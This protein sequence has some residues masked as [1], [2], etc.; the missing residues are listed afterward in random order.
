[1]QQIAGR[2]RVPPTLVDF[3]RLLAAAQRDAKPAT[4]RGGDAFQH[5]FDECGEFRRFDF[6][7]LHHDRTEFLF[8]SPDRSFNDLV[9]VDP[10]AFHQAV[11]APDAAVKAVFR[12]DVADFDQPADADPGP[13]ILQFDPVG[14]VVQL[15][16]RGRIG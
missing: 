15:T 6:A 2:P 4:G 9:G 10:V 7:G 3:G 11:A 12:A 16:Q 8:I 14:A 5:A 13:D 1:M